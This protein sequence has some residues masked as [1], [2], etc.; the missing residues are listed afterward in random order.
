MNR[1]GLI[2]NDIG[3]LRTMDGLMR[4]AIQPLAAAFYSERLGGEFIFESLHTFIVRYRM[5]EDLDLKTHADDSDM[6]FNVCLGKE[7]EGA[8]LYFHKDSGSSCSCNSG[9]S[10]EEVAEEF[11]YPHPATCKYCTFHY[12]HTPGVGL[13]HTGQH[14]HGVEQL[15]K[16]E[17]SNLIFWC[18]KR[19]YPEELR[20]E[21]DKVSKE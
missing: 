10:A 20:A 4:R 21:L 11:S 18:R 12:D 15:T 7:F 3:F 13:M 9:M 17:R 19:P 16:G 14:I 2:L 5:G 8:R 1:Y 6:T